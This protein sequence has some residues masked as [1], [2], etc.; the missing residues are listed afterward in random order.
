MK[1]GDFVL[2]YTD[3]EFDYSDYS[4]EVNSSSNEVYKILNIDEGRDWLQI[5]VETLEYIAEATKRGHKI[6]GWW[7]PDSVI[8]E[9][10]TKET[11][12]EYFI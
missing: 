3:E 6:K 9:V 8:K 5:E 1:I 10:I 2:L 4:V 12:P 11:H 7:L